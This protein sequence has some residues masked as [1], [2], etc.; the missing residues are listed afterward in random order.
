MTDLLADETLPA[1]IVSGLT[2][3][4]SEKTKSEKG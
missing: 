2:A 4:Q 1:K 3:A